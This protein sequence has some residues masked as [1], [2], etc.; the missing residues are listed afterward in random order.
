MPDRPQDASATPAVDDEQPDQVTV[1]RPGQTL[2]IRYARRMLSDY[3]V[4]QLR[5]KFA[6]RMPGVNLVVLGPDIEPVMVYDPN[7]E[8][9]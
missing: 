6:E 9:D 5:A 8:R 7:P 4:D 1:V 3:E 2:V